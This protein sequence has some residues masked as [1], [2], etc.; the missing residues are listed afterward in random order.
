MIPWNGSVKLLCQGTLASYLYQL[1]ILENLTY[2][3]VEKKLGFQEV[4][5]FVIN[6]V[7]TNTAGR[8]QCRYGREHRRSAPSAAL[9]LVVT[10]EALCGSLTLKSFSFLSF[11][12]MLLLE[13]S[14]FQGK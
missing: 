5:E 11:S 12:E 9:E 4:A 7:D 6:H 8:Y 13:V 2:R 3:V 1:E 10:G 14:N